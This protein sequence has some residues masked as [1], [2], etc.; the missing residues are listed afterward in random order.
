M[1]M[2]SREKNK[3]QTG[4]EI[5][6][7]GMALRFPGAQNID[8]FWNN[9][10]NS[11]E[12][13]SFFS[14]DELEKAGVD[15]ELINNPNYVKAGGC[16]KDKETFDASFFG[17]SSIES[18]LMN[19]Q[20]RIFHECAW[21]ALENAG[22]NPAVYD[23]RI[24]LYAGASSGFYWQALSH[25][26]GK[27]RD[28]GS[29]A[30]SLLID[31]DFLCSRVSYNFNLKG[32]SSFVQ[33]ACS[34][35]L[36]AIHHACR[37]LLTGESEMVLAGGASI[38]SAPQQGYSWQEGMILSQDGHCRAFAGNA[39]GT[40]GGEG[41]G[42]VVLKRLKTALEDR[43]HIYAIIKGTAI[44]NDGSRKVG[45][46]APS[47]EAQAEVI[48][49][50]QRMARIAPE[51]ITYIEAHGTGTALGDSVEIEALKLAFNT[52]KKNYCDIGS[53]KTNIGHLDAAAGVAGF[54]KTVLSL[55]YKQI[56]PSLN[57]ETPNPKIDF[58]NSP[59]CVNTTLKKWDGNKYPLR[60]GVSS[61][62]IGGTN[63]HV[64]LEESPVIDHSS[65]V[66]SKCRDYQ[67]IVLSAKTES[68][69][70]KMTEN[71]AGYFKGNQGINLADAA[72][73]LQLGRKAF[74]CRRMLVCSDVK[75]AIEGLSKQES[76]NVRSYFLNK[77]EKD[78]QV[79]FMFSGQGTQ[80]VN[81]GLELY[82]TESV[83]RG[84]MDR[85]FE[86]LESLMD[87]N[88]K[89]IL[90]PGRGEV[91]S[92]TGES[93]AACNLN[94][95]PDINQTWIAQPLLF[96]F[97]YAL[98]KL[99]SHWGVEPYAMI[100]HSIGEYVAACLS[101]VFSLE[102]ALKLVV[103]RGKLMQ[104]M[105]SGAMLGV[106]ASA[107]EL[108]PLLNDEI[109][110]AAVNAPGMCVVSG[111]HQAVDTFENQ[112]KEKE[113]KSRCLHTSHA[114]HSKM[115][116]PILGEYEKQVRQINRNKPG[117]PYISNVTGQWI[118]VEQAL[119]PG[120][121]AVHIR[122][123]VRF[124]DGIKELLKK[125]NSIFV[126]LGPGHSLSAF[127]KK[128]TDEKKEHPTFNL[129]RHPRENISDEAYLLNK[130]GHLWLHG[131][132]IN[133]EQFYREEK[134]NRISLPTY[135][136]ER[137]R[138][139]IEGDLRNTPQN[140]LA[141]KS[142]DTRKELSDWFY[143][144]SWK[145][146]RL[147]AY[148]TETKAVHSGYLVFINDCSLTS[149][150]VKQ[151]EQIG[152]NTIVVKTG[153]AFVKGNEDTYTINPGKKN[154][155][156]LLLKD[157]W[158]QDRNPRYIIHLWG[159]TDQGNE[160]SDIESVTR[161]LELG[162]YSQLY[163]AQAIREQS[164]NNEF[165]ITVI[166]NNIQD[167]TGEEMLCPGKSTV[168]GAVKVIPQEFQQISYSGI[169]IVLPKP[170]SW[171]EN[172]LAARLV[173]EI[174][175]KSPDPIVAYRNNRRWVQTFEQVRLD[176]RIE[177]SLKLREKGVYLVTGGLGG[178]GLVL[179]Q[180]LSKRFKARMIL[181]GGSPFLQRREW[182]NWL[183]THD[184]ENPISRKIRKL[185]TI[186]K[187]GGE[188][189]V[190]PADVTNQQEMEDVICQAKERFG[191]LHGVIHAAGATRENA[192]LCAVE[193]VSKNHCQEQFAP[194]IY[195]LLVL[196]KILKDKDLDF[197]LLMSSLS[198]ILGGLG[199]VAYSA[200]SSF[201]DAFVRNHTPVGSHRWITINWDEWQ[202][203]DQE[204]QD[205]P[206]KA[207]SKKFNIMPGEGEEAMR[208]ILSWNEENQVVVSTRDLQARID[209][210]IKLTSSRHL[211]PEIEES[212][213]Q[214]PR[215]DLGNPYIIPGSRLEQSIAGILQK[216]LGIEKVGRNDNFFDL[217]ITSLDVI[218]IN[219]KLRELVGREIPA[220]TMFT[221][222]TTAS[223]S[224]YLG[225]EETKER[226]VIVDHKT[227][228]SES[229]IESTIL[230]KK[231]MNILG[232]NID[233]QYR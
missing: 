89:E 106:S 96:V 122:S 53:V 153:T 193:E 62:G 139:W 169:D 76:L 217:G 181:T 167:V 231:T 74:R 86:I 83:F 60:A 20:I 146:S 4:M 194:G 77:D 38:S 31:Q 221:Y 191:T 126:E 26:T 190:I 102:N 28:F 196:E 187:M 58:K 216:H 110:L 112:L 113:Y 184:E 141:E 155:Y 222:S 29:F 124:S 161:E 206:G 135:P 111:S 152:G 131:K 147:P 117:I 90:Y 36:V 19:P 69:L 13:I 87:Y 98:A 233:E 41:A 52:E 201:M 88:I 97:E 12:S 63:A 164:L 158:R 229:P 2:N 105:T 40:I 230:L 133:C 18:E 199:S 115:M 186:E 85:C 5:A 47:V 64:V 103:L 91:S 129:V 119:N 123:T 72:Y 171:Q 227:E 175:G 10:K 22:Y 198:S 95:S 130:I 33:T 120:Y 45:F 82:Q 177:G 43:D 188:V 78:K 67:L 71:L 39:S 27:S 32:A 21:E 25:F 208:R 156:V 210:A 68:A 224:E 57:F 202:L 73:T 223:L 59:F 145:R 225:R 79:V 195:G 100:G 99:L 143:L 134:R 23:G 192:N 144:P 173:T 9:I 108:K 11:I 14:D 226:R 212:M 228:S 183:L 42:I 218:Q 182:E 170:G 140:A 35:S 7:I 142:R 107:E 80:Y 15:K 163:L 75:K 34:T 116:E 151:L 44:N 166:S 176:E 24:G 16:F 149:Q 168:L 109:S 46:T 101:G 200:A 159:V 174:L 189:M 165:Q 128:H 136:F 17:Y 138:F 172:R 185:Q 70:N 204:H 30:S 48:C 56:P 197:C 54:I 148:K 209:R 205:S 50:A 118:T 92:P 213:V 132:R 160:K 84:E 180:Y 178:I 121:W 179:S 219:N 220:V 203:E 162:F 125:E 207:L 55:K 65:L 157:L 211:P 127:L 81:M 154:D 93:P 94:L 37:A 137:K 150:L 6:V 3:M 61:F 8:E 66:N 49:I 232:E 114:F 51:T 104:G 1:K 215:P 214:Q